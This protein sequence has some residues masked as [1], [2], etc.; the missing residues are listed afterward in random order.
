MASLAFIFPPFAGQDGG[1]ESLDHGE[2]GTTHSATLRW[3]HVVV[4]RDRVHASEGKRATSLPAE[5]GKG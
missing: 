1:M 5:E 2:P 4:Q 3:K